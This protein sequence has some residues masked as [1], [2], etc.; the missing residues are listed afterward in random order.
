MKVSIGPYL[1]WWG[2]Y[3]LLGLLTKIGFSDDLTHGWAERSPDWLTKACQWIHDKRKRKV[4]IKIDRYDVWSM[5]Y[6]L[7]LIIIPMLKKIKED[8]HGIPMSSFE[9]WDEVDET[10]NHTEAAMKIAEARWDFILDR[11]IWSFKQIIEEESDAFWPV[12]P[13]LD[14]SE[15]PEDEGKLTTPVRWNVEGECNFDALY[16]YHERIQEGLDLFGRH[17]RN[18]WA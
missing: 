6:T 15:H 17:Y 4:E 8:K 18:L 2:P 16:A 5:D 9:E 7:A 14:M 10:G 3:Q 1:N 11:M 12:R 13:E